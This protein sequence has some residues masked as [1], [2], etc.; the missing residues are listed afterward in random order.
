[1]HKAIIDKEMGKRGHNIIEKA[2][3]GWSFSEKAIEDMRRLNKKTIET[4]KEH[5][6]LL[7]GDDKTHKIYL[8]GECIGTD[9]ECRLEFRPKPKE[10]FMGVFHTH[11]GDL[12]IFSPEDISLNVFLNCLGAS[13]AK[14][15][16][17]LQC[18]I[19]KEPLNADK[20][21]RRKDE[22]AVIRG[23]K[24]EERQMLQK[25]YGHIRNLWEILTE[26]YYIFNPE[27]YKDP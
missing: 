4:D 12:H 5:G 6:A 27:K 10:K 16:A 1:M 21:I 3:D 18:L 14:K 13:Y 17:D 22:M 25:R 20:V 24:P 8:S 7:Y 15:G 19:P 9:S 11:H 26:D 2:M 23:E